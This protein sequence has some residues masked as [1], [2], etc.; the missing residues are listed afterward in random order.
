MK[1]SNFSVRTLC[2]AA[3]VAAIVL[4]AGGC[5]ATLKHVRFPVQEGNSK[6]YYEKFFNDGF[7]LDLDEAAA[8][9]AIERNDVDTAVRYCESAVRAHPNDEYAQYDLAIVY[10]IKGNWDGAETAI[11]EAI[12]IDTAQRATAKGQSKRADA[13]YVAELAFIQRHKPARR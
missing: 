12:R 10:E 6:V 2:A 13:D 7:G 5:D 3:L 9:Q 4:A 11:R 1:L 8:Y